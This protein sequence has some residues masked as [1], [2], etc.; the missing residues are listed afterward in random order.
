M[1]LPMQQHPYNLVSSVPIEKY[2]DIFI[3]H[4]PFF[5]LGNLLIILIII[6]I[7]KSGLLTV[8]SIFLLLVGCVLQIRKDLNTAVVGL[9]SR[10]GLCMKLILI[11]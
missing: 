7:E 8:F 4:P 11:S 10:E 5:F 3:M 1:Y 6:I 9:A 2:L